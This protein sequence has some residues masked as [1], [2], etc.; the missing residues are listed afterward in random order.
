MVACYTAKDSLELPTLLPA[1]T[2][3]K[4]TRVLG[5]NLGPLEKQPVLL[6]HLSRPYRLMSEECISTTVGIT[7]WENG[8]PSHLLAHPGCYLCL[9]VEISFPTHSKDTCSFGT[10]RSE[11]KHHMDPSRAEA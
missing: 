6:S 3:G 9:R 4:L 10:H 11:D 2:A 1:R 5:S 8:K 7:H